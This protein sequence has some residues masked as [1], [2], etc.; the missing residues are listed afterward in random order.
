MQKYVSFV[1][2]GL[3]GIFILLSLLV[4]G[5]IWRLNHAPLSLNHLVKPY[6][7]SAEYPIEIQ[8]IQLIW[9]GWKNPFVVQAHHIVIEKPEKIKITIPLLE[10]TFKFSGLYKKKFLPTFINIM[11]PVIDIKEQITLTDFQSS[12]TKENIFRKLQQFQVTGITIINNQKLIIEKGDFLGKRENKQIKGSLRFVII[13]ETQKLPL[14]IDFVYKLQESQLLT[15]IL[16]TE[17]DLLPWFSYFNTF[18]VKAPLKAKLTVEWQCNKS[19]SPI[20]LQADIEGLKGEIKT[21]F[22][23]KPFVFDKF[24]TQMTIKKN[25]FFL[26]SF[27]ILS[28]DTVVTATGQVNLPNNFFFSIAQNRF[29]FQTKTD[30]QPRQH[31]SFQVEGKNLN[32]SSVISGWPLNKLG[33][34]RSWIQEHILQGMIETMTVQGQGETSFDSQVETNWA[35]LDGAATFNNTQLRY[36]EEMPDLKHMKGTLRF[37]QN[38]LDIQLHSG[39]C[40][41]LKLAESRFTIQ[42]FDPTAAPSILDLKFQ[43][44]TSDFIT[45]LQTPKLGLLGGLPLTIQP[46]T[47]TIEGCLKLTFPLKSQLTS[48]EVETDFKAT[49]KNT[50]VDLKGLTENSL[51]LQQHNLTCTFS[52]LLLQMKGD[53]KVHDMPTTYQINYHLN[54]NLSLKTHSKVETGHLEKIWPDISKYGQGLMDL[55]LTYT[56]DFTKKNLK[57]GLQATVNL[58]QTILMLSLLNWNKEKNVPLALDFKLNSRGNFIDFTVDS[59]GKMA[60]VTGKGT[61]DRKNSK[62][63]TLDMPVINLGKNNFSCF[64]DSHLLKIK[65]KELDLQN[66]LQP[67]KSNTFD[68]INDLKVTVDLDTLIINPS[69]PFK[70]LIFRADWRRGYLVTLLLKGQMQQKKHL[71]PL[72]IHLHTTAQK[73]LF[74]LDTPNGGR[75]LHVL[76]ITDTIKDGH[77]KI[78]GEQIWG[79]KGPSGH[80]FKFSA[81]AHDFHVFKAGFFAHLFSLAMVVGIFDLV[82][83]QGVAFNEAKIKF[84]VKDD[85]T[86]V[87]EKAQVTGLSL[88][89]T[90]KG[91]LNIPHDT[92]ALEGT[93]IPAYL[94]NSA[95]SHIPLVGQLLSGGRKGIFATSYSVTGHLKKP[96]IQAN[97]LSTLT[98]GFIQELFSPQETSTNDT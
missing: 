87:I 12:N 83:G 8:D 38:S 47:G 19:F 66:A 2:K 81:T 9:Q 59:I 89:L 48:Q 34:V 35:A 84:A 52:S 74:S 26:K 88:G 63:E 86:I 43:G 69:T 55:N 30:P 56:K 17:S 46:K 50:D 18:E 91:T 72:D 78:T 85:Q 60:Q 51:L 10:L 95:L 62:L 49:L 14:K 97:P 82:R 37:N 42:S 61:W 5:F 27:K 93:L 77:L 71:S 23:E 4:G 16:W 32:W 54:K 13:K 65:G 94:I 73:R 31:F 44:P 33:Y 57:E 3:L 40:Q 53:G 96:K 29:D 39:T 24:E 45:I 36:L 21:D 79:S 15:S 67:S 98:P 70:H 1:L 90:A 75:L 41:N 7:Q 11:D 76:N 28:Q 64:F 92:I 80:P 25:I 68:D 20:M 58:D 22:L 6:I